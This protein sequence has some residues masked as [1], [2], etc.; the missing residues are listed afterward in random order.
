M[1]RIRAKRDGELMEAPYEIYGAGNNRD[2]SFSAQIGQSKITHIEKLVSLIPVPY[3][4][5]WILLAA[6]F[7]SISYLVLRMFE[8]SSTYIGAFLIISVI[9]ALEGTAIIVFD[10]TFYTI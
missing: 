6:A 4:L 5:G 2:E 1:V 3:Y 7:F 9:I 10:K 8:E